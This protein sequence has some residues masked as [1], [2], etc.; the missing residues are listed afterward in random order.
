M[1]KRLEELEELV[2]NKPQKVI[3][4]AAAEDS[5]IMQIGRAHV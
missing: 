4:V 1:L 5:D 3:G 2:K